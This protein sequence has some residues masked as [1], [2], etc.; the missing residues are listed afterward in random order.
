VFSED[1]PERDGTMRQVGV[2]KSTLGGLA[3]VAALAACDS[4][5]PPKSPDEIAAVYRA[6]LEE[7]LQQLRHEFVWLCD[8]PKRP[9]NEPCGTL[10]DE[11]TPDRLAKLAHE[12][13]GEDPKDVSE[14]SESCDDHLQGIFLK[15][16]LRRYPLATPSE[17]KSDCERTP[18]AC[19]TL[20]RTEFVYLNIHNAAVL[21][22]H[23][24]TIAEIT[25]EEESAQ[26]QAAQQ[27]DA[28]EREAEQRRRVLDRISAAFS[29]YAV[30]LQGT[31]VNSSGCSS[32]YMCGMGF[33]CVK[34]AYQAIGTCMVATNRYGTPDPSSMPRPS[35][36]GVG[37][38]ECISLAECPATFQCVAGH[39]VK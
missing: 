23:K 5:P 32:D 33:V 24:A 2:C 11:F 35:S 22:R 38:T 37:A 20:R 9:R 19:S 14:I 12:L 1:E 7:A 8:T 3:L 31:T 29:G 17:V 6:R 21:A 13:C 15:A 18:D 26:R 34:P 30:G 10:A 25:R 36:V 27:R 4:G 28:R 39:C 16:L